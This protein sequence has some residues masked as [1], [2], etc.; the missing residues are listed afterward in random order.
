MHHPSK[1]LFLFIT[2]FALI[3]TGCAAFKPAARTVNNVA[4][5]ACETAFGVEDLPPGI[6]V[7]DFCEAHEHVQPFI[8]QILAAKA[9]LKAGMDTSAPPPSE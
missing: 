4:R 6:S 2:T 1:L 5:L 9:G 3:F 7:K 8:D